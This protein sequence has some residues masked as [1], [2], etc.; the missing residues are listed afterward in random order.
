[1]NMI[2]YIY[3]NI[4]I[5][6]VSMFILPSC[7]DYLDV[8]P[9]KSFTLETVFSTR[10]EAYNALA[11]CYF[12]LPIDGKRNSGWMLGD[13]WIQPQVY[14]ND[15]LYEYNGVR[16]MER[17]Q[18]V[19]APLLGLW[20]GSGYGKPL[21]QG[22]NSCNIFID[23]IDEVK[24]MENA[25]KADWKAQVIFMKAYY[26][27]LLLRQYGPILIMDKPTSPDENPASLYMSRS[28]ID[29]CFDYIVQTIDK[30]I[31][32]L[33]PR[34][35]GTDLGQIDKLGAA[36]IKAR[37]LLYRAS[38]FY[39]GNSADYNDFYDWD[40]KPFFP[41]DDAATTK[42]KWKDAAD[43][44]D[45]AIAL[46]EAGKVEMYHYDKRILPDDEDDA[47]ANPK[48]MQTLYD[49]RMVICDR[50]NKEL[51]WGNSNVAADGQDMFTDA[52]IMITPASGYIGTQGPNHAWNILG[53]T[54]KTLERYY[55]K[56][57][58][59]L[60]EDTTFH[61]TTMYK[62]THTP[63]SITDPA[64]YA[65][66][67]GILQSGAETINLYLNREPR[68]YANV[69]ITGGYWR[70]HSIRH[71]TTFYTSGIGGRQLNYAPNFFWT[72]IGAQ[73]VVHIDNKAATVRDQVPYPVPI[74]R[75]SDL[76]LMKAEAYNEY[77]DA[78]TKADVWEPI[79][80]VRERAGIPSVEESYSGAFVTP[81]AAGKHTRKAGMR[82][83]I[84]Q[85]RK[86][87]FAFEG[88]I[89]WDMLRTRKAL[90]EF[91]S[92]AMGWKFDATT[93]E[94]FFQLQ[95]VQPRMFTLRDCLWPIANAELDKNS[96]L[97]QN[98]GW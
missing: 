13:E 3:K 69:G 97:I 94:N 26:H 61:R 11:K 67:R 88:H 48:N 40:R 56:N 77:L 81:E 65:E 62:L 68:F 30:A 84:A 16:I 5:V 37:V 78:P 10:T 63:D 86:V 33:L 64:G 58:L 59:T 50:W 44:I 45:A 72:A 95:I 55:T 23:K 93:G 49:L 6:V 74:I 12:Y 25:E 85:E 36:A 8:V 82:E 39:S 19:G 38:P 14:E 2:K 60:D 87:E 34:R 4:I 75:L 79:N 66:T 29:D 54:Y 47:K 96:R 70:S 73:K 51:I 1:M 52:N 42:A 35:T 27:F 83:I 28:K 76:Y 92:P 91:S 43:A 15:R 7:S 20:T 21:Y 32:N 31:P 18:T 80:K 41:Q 24:D 90:T 57:G 98:P 9:D 71:S 17:K 22:I 46:C 53:A 89:F